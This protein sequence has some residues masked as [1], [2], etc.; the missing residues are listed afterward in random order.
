MAP[1]SRREFL[2]IH[3][4]Y[5]VWIHSETRSR[6]DTTCKQ[7]CYFQEIQLLQFM[8][9]MNMAIWVIDTLNQLFITGSYNE[10]K[11]LKKVK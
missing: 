2:D 9:N 7:Y 11:L 5:R 4:N 3:A 10:F 1:A 6:H 8:K